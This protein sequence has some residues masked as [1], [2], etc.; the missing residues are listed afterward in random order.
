MSY[1]SSKT[2]LNAITVHYARALAGTPIKVNGAA[3]GHVAT[4]F[5]NFRGS[6][7]PEQGAAVAI[8][9]ATLPADG[10]TGTVFEDHTQLAW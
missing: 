5:N 6:R 10:P 3:P 7:T 2:A 8:H 1:S 4:D 9:L